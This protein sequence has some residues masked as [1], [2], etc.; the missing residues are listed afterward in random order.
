MVPKNTLIAQS[1]NR[2]A[3]LNWALYKQKSCQ[4]QKTGTSC[5]AALT[6]GDFQRISAGD[7]VLLKVTWTTL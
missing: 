2:R 3:Y 5:Q 7:E 6:C 1:S 4:I